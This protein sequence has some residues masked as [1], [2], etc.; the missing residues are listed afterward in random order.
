MLF[1]S[2]YYLVFLFVCVIIFYLIPS[3]TGKKYFLLVSS[4]FLVGSFSIASLITVTLLNFF[5]YTIAFSLQKVKPSKKL[6]LFSIF[7]NIL[8]I[9]LYKFS[10]EYIFKNKTLP[11]G[12]SSYFI[13]VGLSF[14]TLQNI[15]YLVDVY[16]KRIIAGTDW[17]NFYL[18][19]VLFMRFTSGP[20]MKPAQLFEDFNNLPRRFDEKLFSSGFQRILLGL[21]KKLVIADRFTL[22]VAST[23]DKHIFTSTYDTL[24]AVCLY[25][26][27][28]YFDF[29]GYI[30]IALGS[31]K[32]FGITLTENFNLPFRASSVSEFWRR[33]HISLINWLTNYVFYPVNYKLRKFGKEAA[34]IAIYTTFILSGLWHSLKI[35]YILWA[36]CHCVYLSFELYTKNRRLKLT[37]LGGKYYYYLSILLTFFLVSFSH[38]FFR[39][40]NFSEAKILLSSLVDFQHFFPNVAFNTWLMDGGWEIELAFNLRVGIIATI[41]FLL[42]EKRINN[43]AKS[44]SINILYVISIITLIFVFGIFDSADRFIYMQF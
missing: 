17:V 29:S 25:T 14:Y 31:A 38:L 21:F 22:F 7:L 42:F 20:I 32:L 2:L 3:L 8:A 30:D 9:F 37:K 43:Y 34:F 4:L 19:N 11:S 36:L 16:K 1:N 28:L 24:L 40:N 41:V 5:N 23:F 35:T 27:Q 13:I 26:I 15:S 10:E 33:W 18:T 39:A 12:I 44:N 6:F